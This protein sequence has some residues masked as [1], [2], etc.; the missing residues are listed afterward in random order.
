MAKVQF[1]APISD[2]RGKAGGLV[3]SKNASGNFCKAWMK[4]TNPSTPKQA[5]Q[6]SFLAQ[7]GANWRS[8]TSGQQDDWNTFA[9]SPPET[10]YDSLGNAY[11]L[12]G[13]NWMCRIAVRLNRTGQTEDLIAPISTP[14]TPPTTFTMTLYP[15]NGDEDRAEIQYSSG[16]FVTEYAILELSLAPGVGSNVQT[17]RYLKCWEALGLELT[18][19]EFGGNYYEAFG[20]TQVDNRFFARLYRQ[21]DTGIRS[22]PLEL[23]VDVVAYP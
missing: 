4:P 13:F 22:T 2:M 5:L 18:S 3:Y 11:L 9:A 8:L 14:T 21:A 12:S 17:S 16:E 19:T 10:D 1:V 6:R 7:M 20:A 23:F 15:A